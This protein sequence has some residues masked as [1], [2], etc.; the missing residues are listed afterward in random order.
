MGLRQTLKMAQAIEALDNL[1]VEKLPRRS[2]SMAKGN[3]LRALLGMKH[4]PAGKKYLAKKKKRTQ[5]VYFK[6][7]RRDTVETKLRKNKVGE[8]DIKKMVGA[9]NYVGP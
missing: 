3:I 1:I 7:I 5:P 2:T 8:D 6:H 9:K 4:S